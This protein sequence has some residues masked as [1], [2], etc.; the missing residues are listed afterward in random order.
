MEVT[1]APGASPEDESQRKW[2]MINDI[3][4]WFREDDVNVMPEDL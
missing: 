4:F 3:S 1:L 2:H